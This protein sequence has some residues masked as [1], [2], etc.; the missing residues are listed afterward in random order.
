MAKDYTTINLRASRE[1]AERLEDATRKLE[2]NVSSYV[3]LAVQRQ[4]L[5]DAALLEQA[6][7]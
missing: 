5:A 2:T 6:A 3:R 1:F 4:L 7:A